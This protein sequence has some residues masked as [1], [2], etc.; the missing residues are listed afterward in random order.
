MSQPHRPAV[1]GLIGAEWPRMYRVA[2]RML[3]DT[4]RAHDAAQ[5]A[6][7]RALAGWE[8][9]NGSCSVTTW[10]HRI[11]VNCA[12]DVLRSARRQDRLDG[13]LRAQPPGTRPEPQPSE[14]AQQRELAD[15][16]LSLLDQLPEDCR[17]S[18]ALT[19]LDGYSYEQA[20]E[21]QSLPRGTVASRVWRAKR[22]LLEQMNARTG[23]KA[24]P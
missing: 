6:C 22:T 7:V 4:E 10:L 21:V 15:L 1:P 23:T 13:A 17:L 2:L 24:Q 16:A 12:T 14:L 18:F 19:Q 8:G 3:N 5:E 20:A 9:F 11:T